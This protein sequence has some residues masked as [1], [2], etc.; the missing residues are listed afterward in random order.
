MRLRIIAVS[1]LVKCAY[2]LFALALYYGGQNLNVVREGENGYE[3]SGS[4]EGIISIFFR[5]DSGWYQKIAKEGHTPTPADA[6]YDPICKSC[7]QSTYAF[8]PL[9][10]ALLRGVMELFGAS[11]LVSAFWTQVVLST[12]AFLLFFQFCETYYHSKTK[13]YYATLTLILFPFHFYFSQI[14]TESLYFLL[15]IGAFYTLIKRRYGL[16]MLVSALL[17]LTRPNGVFA[18]IPLGI[19]YVSRKPFDFRTLPREITNFI[20][21]SLPA[22]LAFGAYCSYLYTM[23]G[24]YFA[25]NTAQRAWNRSFMF[26]F[27]ALFREGNWRQQSQSIY[28][29]LITL[30]ALWKGRALPLYQN[31]FFWIN[32]LVPLTAGSTLSMQRFV[33]VNFPFVFMLNDLFYS[34]RARFIFFGFLLILHLASYYSWLIDAPISW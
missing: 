28:V 6:L 2:I 32:F 31:F 21:L 17:A 20:L 26:P 29:L 23:T 30:F 15:V 4:F 1:L 8:F 14:Y 11:F 34:P 7:C 10:P 19:L 33:S 18:F 27:A 3:F 5:G 9:Y 12:A 16:F 22:A 24:D 25:F 13:A